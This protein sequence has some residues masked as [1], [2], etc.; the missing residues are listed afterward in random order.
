MRQPETFHSRRN[1]DEVQVG[2]SNKITRLQSAL[3]VLDE[4]DETERS[5]L[6]VALKKAQ[7]Q[8]VIP[9]VL[10]QIEHTQKFIERAKKLVVLADE[11]VQ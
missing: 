2:A 6:E 3:A 9:S 1:P 5:A 10:E 7:A 8:D 11:Y 4:D